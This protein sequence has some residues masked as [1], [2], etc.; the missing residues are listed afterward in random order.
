MSCGHFC[1]ET[2]AV[3][4][5]SGVSVGTT[6]SVFFYCGATEGVGW[7]RRHREILRGDSGEKGV[8][9]RLHR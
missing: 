1:G 2:Y 9:T 8:K 7:A 5:D 4:I 3:K 6:G